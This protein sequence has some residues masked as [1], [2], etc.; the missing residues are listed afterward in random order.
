MNTRYS[1]KDPSP[2]SNE[3]KQVT[4]LIMTTDDMTRWIQM[5]ALS[6]GMKVPEVYYE[7]LQVYRDLTEM[8]LYASEIDTLEQNKTE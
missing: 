8:K 4:R 5:R 7:A 2:P 6:T 1:Y 3:P